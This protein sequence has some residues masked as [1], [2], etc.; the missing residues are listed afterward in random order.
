M[1]VPLI[2]FCVIFLCHSY[3]LGQGKVI[4]KY[5]KYQKFDFEDLVVEG[6]S[7]SPG[8]LSIMSRFQK[9]FKNKLPYRR[10]FNPEIVKSI[11]SIR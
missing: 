8:D 9:K 6:D 3:V 1:K 11:E 10:N 7:G 2:F 5:K 4:Y